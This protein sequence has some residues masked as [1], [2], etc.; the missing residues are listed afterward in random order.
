MQR[1]LAVATSSLESLIF[2]CGNLG[3]GESKVLEEWLD[4]LMDELQSQ[5]T[6]II[7]AIES[8]S[9]RS[10]ALLSQTEEVMGLLLH[11]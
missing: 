10:E 4:G 7:E 5:R 6:S 11:S 1:F 2:M 8:L 9:D 3:A